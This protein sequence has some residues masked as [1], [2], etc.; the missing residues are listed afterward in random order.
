MHKDG[1][2]SYHLQLSWGFEDLIN[3]GITVRF[4]SIWSSGVP[5][6]AA[7]TLVIGIFKLSTSRQISLSGCIFSQKDFTQLAQVQISS[8]GEATPIL[9]IVYQFLAHQFQ[10]PKSRTKSQPA[11]K[12]QN[13]RL[14]FYHFKPIL[15]WETSLKQ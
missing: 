8:D 6:E 7:V 12:A 4:C 14:K 5:N 1:R 13:L 9:A 11:K 2:E 3:S 15:P 10:A